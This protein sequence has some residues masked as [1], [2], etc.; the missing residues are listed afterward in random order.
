MSM[1]DVETM[2]FEVNGT[3]YVA[4]ISACDGECAT[5]KSLI[6]KAGEE[7]MKIKFKI[8]RDLKKKWQVEPEEAQKFLL[9]FAKPYTKVRT[10]REGLVGEEEY[11]FDLDFAS[12]KPESLV[13]KINGEWQTI[14]G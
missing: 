4:A 8:S 9:A 11:V 7:A 2:N 13:E 1:Q 6:S 10:A 12:V 14:A 3:A 5:V